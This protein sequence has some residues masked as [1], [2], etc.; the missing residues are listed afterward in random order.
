M[1]QTLRL[2]KNNKEKKI[3]PIVKPIL[4]ESDNFNIEI[5]HL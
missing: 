3:K 1:T 4:E 5:P 2:K